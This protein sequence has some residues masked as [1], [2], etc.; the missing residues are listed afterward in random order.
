VPADAVTAS[1]SGLDPGISPAYARLQAATVAR[2]RGIT[3]SQADALITRN[4]TGRALGFMGEPWVNVVTLN[5]QL[6]QK[7]PYRK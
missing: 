5:H 7:Y 4:T 6:D 3:L 1:G 2:T